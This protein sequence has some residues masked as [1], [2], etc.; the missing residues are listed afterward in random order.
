MNQNTR[1]VLILVCIAALLAAAFLC[2]K[3]AQ[4]PGLRVGQ[5]TVTVSPSGVAVTPAA[6]P[7]DLSTWLQIAAGILAVIEVAIQ[8]IIKLVAN[9]GTGGTNAASTATPAAPSG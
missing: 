1:V 2:R 4:K 3:P 8:S 9:R 5:S 7:V 6:D